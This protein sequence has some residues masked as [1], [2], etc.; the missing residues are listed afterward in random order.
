MTE[1]PFPQS[2]DKILEKVGEKRF[3]EVILKI[4]SANVVSELNFDDKDKDLI[5]SLSQLGI[6]NAESRYFYERP[7]EEKTHYD[8]FSISNK[9]KAIVDS[10]LRKLDLP[11]RVGFFASKYP[12]KFLAY[13]VHFLI[14]FDNVYNTSEEEEYRR[15]LQKAEFASLLQDFKKDLEKFVCGFWIKEHSSKKLEVKPPTL[16]LLP[17][18]L[19]SLKEQLPAEIVETEMNEFRLAQYVEEFFLRPPTKREW[20][21]EFLRAVEREKLQE[22]WKS[23]LEELTSNGIIVD[24]VVLDP[25]GLREFLAAKVKGIQDLI[26]TRTRGEENIK[27]FQKALDHRSI[28]V[29]ETDRNYILSPCRTRKDFSV[30]V[31]AIYKILHDHMQIKDVNVIDPVRCYFHHDK[32]DKQQEWYKRKFEEFCM[33]N[34]LHFPPE[35]DEEWEILKE[36]IVE[37]AIKR[38]EQLK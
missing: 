35:K 24:F 8:L 36:K 18:F 28:Q 11:N 27:R 25:N 23:W 12:S 29:N 16:F 17:E 6:I 2:V 19:N 4:Y 5:L 1:L 38:L 34:L 32:Q 37:R 10:I 7:Y 26:A 13:V 31:S 21:E 30:F 22:M 3:N 15:L 33:E 14:A 20:F 9:G